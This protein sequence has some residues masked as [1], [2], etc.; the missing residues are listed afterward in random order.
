VSVLRDV[1]IP[2][3]SGYVVLAGVVVYAARHPEAARPGDASE[4]WRESFRLVAVTVGGGFV[5]FVSIVLVF[6]TWIVGQRGALR[7]ALHGGAFLAL[8]CACTFV[9]L[10]AAEASTRRR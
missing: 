1:V 8:V 3:V 2:I 4:G 10:S 6:H 7:S 9:A 5:V